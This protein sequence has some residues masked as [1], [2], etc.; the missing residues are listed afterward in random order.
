MHFIA[1]GAVWNV[2]LYVNPPSIPAPPDL[3]MGVAPVI[4][5]TMVNQN[6]SQ[7]GSDEFRLGDNAEDVMAAGVT[8]TARGSWGRMKMLYR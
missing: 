2:E 3:V 7:F 1:G 6:Q 8:P 4:Y 5:G